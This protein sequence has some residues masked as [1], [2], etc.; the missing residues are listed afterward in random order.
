MKTTKTLSRRWT[1]KNL[2]NQETAT[3]IHPNFLGALQE[4]SN[5]WF[6]SMEVGDWRHISRSEQTYRLFAK[7]Q[8]LHMNA[9]I[10]GDVGYL[11]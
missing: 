2:N 1:F 4:V 8:A 6:E 9:R 5:V 10:I 11:G 7:G 3:V